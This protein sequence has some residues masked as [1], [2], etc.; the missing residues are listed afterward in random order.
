MCVVYIVCVCVCAY[1]MVEE[2]LKEKILRDMLL[3]EGTC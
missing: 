3:H 1:A 2:A